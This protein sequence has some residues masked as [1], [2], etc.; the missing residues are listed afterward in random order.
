MSEARPAEHFATLDQQE[1]VARLGMW[2]FLAT[3][4]LFFGGLFLAYA[5]YRARYPDAFAAAGEHTKVVIG[6]INTAILLT[7]SFIMAL[8]VKAAEADRRRPLA[9]YLLATALLGIVFLV[10]KG[11]EY[12]GEYRE[13]LVPGLN[14]IF[15]AR[16]ASAAELFFLLYFIMT[17]LHAVHMAIGVCLLLIFAWRA[18]RGVF[19]G[20]GKHMPVTVLGLY[21]HFV[22]LVWVFLFPLL[23]LNGRSP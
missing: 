2:V 14:F 18:K 15:K 11:F 3:E 8:G 12:A 1:E 10:L 19:S 17:G 20:E 9:R 16:D 23:Y 4:V 7:S 21:W 22:D 13:H 6:T 5:I